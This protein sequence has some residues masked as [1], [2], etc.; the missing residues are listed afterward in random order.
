MKIIKYATSS[1]KAEG[2]ILRMIA[3]GKDEKSEVKAL[4]ATYG[5]EQMKEFSSNIKE[6]LRKIPSKVLGNEIKN[7][8]DRTAEKVYT[9]DASDAMDL[10]DAVQVKKNSRGY[11]LSVYIA[12]VSHYVKDG[13]FLN[14]EAI[15]RGTSIYVP[16]T[17]IPMLPKKLSN[18]ICSLNQG[19]KRLT[20]AIDILFDKDGNVCLLYTS[21]CR[22]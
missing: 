22:R 17:V 12:D 16:G 9:I 20:L 7:R 1:S 19:V 18:G 13:T 15:Y 8:V 3:S 4:S 11:I 2:K 14:K 5:L 10:D 21:R 6:E